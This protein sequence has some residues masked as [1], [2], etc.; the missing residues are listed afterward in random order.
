MNLADHYRATLEGLT[1]D[2][3]GGPD[4]ATTVAAGRRR[5]RTRRTA[6]AGGAVAALVIAGV[7]GAWLQRP[8]H[9]VAIDGFASAPA[10]QDFVP[11][12]DIDQTIQE[13]VAEHLPG[14][15]E[16]KDVYPSDW[17][18]DTALPDAQAANATDWE[19]HYVLSAHEKATV[20]MFKA[21]PG[22]AAPTR[23]T[24]GMDNPGLPCTSVTLG[25]GSVRLYYAMG[26]GTFYRIAT[27]QVAPDGSVVQ[28]F[29][30]VEGSSASEA[31][32]QATLPQG[33]LDGLVGDAAMTFPNPVVTPPPPTS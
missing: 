24:D 22:E 31:L 16:A 2:R 30:D 11:G 28:V 12:T 29:D 26:L 33:R 20:S 23:C 14:L 19:A 15:V 10:Y 21:I 1:D 9:E 3:P 4:L 17:N 13:T 32:R 5:R 6:V 8:H 27:V 7:A 25:D 18:R